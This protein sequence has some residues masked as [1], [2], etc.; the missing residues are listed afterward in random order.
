MSDMRQD[1]SSQRAV[2]AQSTASA[3]WLWAARLLLLAALAICI[4]LAYSALTHSPVIGCG[5]EEACDRV[6]Q[7]HWAY[8]FNM[9]VSVPAA[10]VYGVMLLLTFI[11]NRGL[12]THRRTAWGWLLFWSAGVLLTILWMVFL[13]AAIIGEF[14][15]V[16]MSAHI[17]GALAVGSLLVAAPWRHGKRQLVDRIDPLRFTPNQAAKWMALGCVPFLILLAGQWVSQAPRGFATARINGPSV[18]SFEGTVASTQ[19][20]SQP[21]STTARVEL[22][23]GSLGPD[24]APLLGDPHAP[25]M[26][27]VLFDYTCDHC[28]EIHGRLLEAQAHFNNQF[29]V[30]LLPT[31]LSHECNPTVKRSNPAACELA[32]LG[33]AVWV[34]DKDAFKS[35]DQFMMATTYAPTPDQA[36]QWAQEHIGAAKLAAAL[37]SP[38]IG[39]L[40]AISAAAYDDNTARLNNNSSLPQVVVGT[41]LIQGVPPTVQDLYHILSKELSLTP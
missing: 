29:S 28:R 37:K 22:S 3:G 26:I 18:M 20:S 27:G 25:K 17:S 5:A 11:A 8:A 39:R 2:N 7:T 33:L 19:S 4:S 9:P 10:L 34:A 23:S 21:I 32:K 35:F 15:K 36:R 40:L 16:C 13:Q 31:P 41:A 12:L 24:D 30:L 38:Q 6:Q 14:C 1:P